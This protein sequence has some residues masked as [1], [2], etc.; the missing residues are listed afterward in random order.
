MW[1]LSHKYFSSKKDCQLPSVSGTRGAAWQLSPALPGCRTLQH[2]PGPGVSCKAP[3]GPS[4]LPWAP[5][6]LRGLPRP[7]GNALQSVWIARNTKPRGTHRMRPAGWWPQVPSLATAL[8]HHCL[9]RFPLHH[10]PV[11]LAR[12]PRTETPRPS[13]SLS[14]IPT[15][16]LALWL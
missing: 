16:P 8:P 1:L 11:G 5:K 15:L 9:S 12:S 4:S 13:L 6:H 14:P 3:S 7:E 10:L 2:S